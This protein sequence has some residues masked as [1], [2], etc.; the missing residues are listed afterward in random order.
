MS[1]QEELEKTLRIK[2][3]KAWEKISG[4]KASDQQI[5]IFRKG[6]PS[7]VEITVSQKDIVRTFRG[8]K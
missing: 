5:F 8:I 4:V 3:A 1:H 2:L 7:F 6:R